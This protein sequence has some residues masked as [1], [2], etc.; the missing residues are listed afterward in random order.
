VGV[1]RTVVEMSLDVIREP[2]REMTSWLEDRE[3]WY[4]CYD[5]G[6]D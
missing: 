5:E 6:F 3:T 2:E 1:V 4:A